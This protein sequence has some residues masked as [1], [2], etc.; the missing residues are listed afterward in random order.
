M[1]FHFKSKNRF[2]SKQKLVFLTGCFFSTNQSLASMTVG[3]TGATTVLTGAASRAGNYLPKNINGIIPKNNS[4]NAF[5]KFSQM[6][7]STLQEGLVPR[8]VGKPKYQDL[9]KVPRVVGK[10]NNLD[11]SGTGGQSAFQDAQNTANQTVQNALKQQPYK[12]KIQLDR[13]QAAKQAEKSEEI[14]RNLV[15][16]EIEQEA[17]GSLRFD[18]QEVQQ[19]AKSLKG[20]SKSARNVKLEEIENIQDLADVLDQLNSS[21]VEQYLKTLDKVKSDKVLS[22][23]TQSKQS[24]VRQ[25]LDLI[26]G[27]K[28]SNQRYQNDLAR[29]AKN[30]A[31][32]IQKE[33]D[34]KKRL[35]EILNSEIESVKN[36]GRA[37]EPSS[38]LISKGSNSLI[39]TPKSIGSSNN[40]SSSHE[41]Y[42]LIR[43]LYN[44]SG[45]GSAGSRFGNA[46]LR[47]NYSY[48]TAAGLTALAG[49][50]FSLDDRE[51]Q[52]SPL[53][54]RV[55]TA[56][57][58]YALCAAVVAQEVEQR[59]EQEA[60][61]M[62]TEEMAEQKDGQPELEQTD[63]QNIAMQEAAFQR[64]ITAEFE[65]LESS[66]SDAQITRYAQIIKSLYDMIDKL[67]KSVQDRLNQL[68]GFAGKT[69]EAIDKRL[70]M[71]D[72]VPLSFQEKLAQILPY[73]KLSA[74]DFKDKTLPEI[75][76]LIEL[77]VNFL[78]SKMVAVH[79]SA[80]RAV[81][82]LDQKIKANLPALKE[83]LQEGLEKSSAKIYYIVAQLRSL[84]SN[85]FADLDQQGRDMRNMAN[86]SI[87]KLAEFTKNNLPRTSDIKN[88]M[89]SV[90]HAT[91][92]ATALLQA[93]K[94][95]DD[96]LVTMDNLKNVLPGDVEA[97]PFMKGY[98]QS[99]LNR[100]SSKIAAQS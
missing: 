51:K 25:E 1:S 34:D 73:L 37:Q 80:D 85:K 96:M 63:E 60:D 12:S 46:R 50:I 99:R 31:D 23:M 54:Q 48:A 16:Q 86:K 7:Q 69:V 13:E 67:P 75:V 21:Q 78:E 42:E 39:V 57:Q 32:R 62:V 64:A 91:D 38:L 9:P 40:S 95:P 47:N 6:P 52:K 56:N 72:I 5:N 81:E 3:A 71:M 8:I 55:D 93:A 100:I 35:E 4:G 10:P 83:A 92:I 28:A 41:S 44:S 82:S 90:Q 26:S 97:T 19:I 89:Y 68:T 59:A 30:K 94:S 58:L 33:T 53:A 11:W 29:A 76:Q 66:G 27:S 88:R 43:N 84:A 65:A 14:L 61:K 2:F 74:Q 49:Y 98:V 70:K 18:A 20:M 17:S 36:L 22:S 15:D 77:H 87:D 24:A 79:E 45:S